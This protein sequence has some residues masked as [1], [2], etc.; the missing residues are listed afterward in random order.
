MGCIC[1][2]SICGVALNPWYMRLTVHLIAAQGIFIGGIVFSLIATIIG[3]RRGKPYRRS[4]AVVVQAAVAVALMSYFGSR[5]FNRLHEANGPDGD[6]GFLLM[7]KDFKAY[8]KGDTGLQ[9][10]PT[11]HGDVDINL[12]AFFEWVLLLS[13]VSLAFVKLIFELHGGVKLGT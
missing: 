13:V 9:G 7:A 12:A 6:S 3:Y 4:L 10:G 1:S 2:L 11:M 5:G 8:C